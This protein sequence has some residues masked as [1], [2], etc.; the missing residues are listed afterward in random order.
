MRAEGLGVVMRDL[1][2]VL[3]AHNRDEGRDGIP[4]L[5]GPCLRAVFRFSD[6]AIGG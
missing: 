1:G 6:H 4:P 2:H 5:I 3:I